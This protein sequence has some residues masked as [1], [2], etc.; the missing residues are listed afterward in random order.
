MFRAPREP[1]ALGVP[2]V[3]L[4]C[5]V[6]ASCG[7]RPGL[8]RAGAAGAGGGSIVVGT[9]G[10]AGKAAGAGGA[11]GAP[12]GAACAAA[13]ECAAPA[14]PCE[15]ATCEAGRCALAAV[16]AGTVVAIDQP[17]D[18][19]DTVCDGAGGAVKVLDLQ[20]V[21]AAGPCQINACGDDGRIVGGVAVAGAPCGGG[22]GLCDGKGL[23]V[24]CLA[25]ADCNGPLICDSSRACV[26]PSCVDGVQ[27][28]AE[29]DVDCGGGACA[30]CA[31]GQG[32]AYDADCGSGLC[33]LSDHVC[34]TPTCT[35]ERK[36][37]DETDIDCGGSCG[38]C[39]TARECRVDA[40]C[41]TKAC[42]SGLPHRCLLDHCLDGHKDF[43]ETDRDCGG[44]TCAKC[45]DFQGCKQDADCQSGHCPPARGWCLTATCFNGVH[46]GNETGVDCGGGL[47]A[48]CALGQGCGI[49]YDCASNA[50]DFVALTC[51]ADACADHRLEN[52]E[53][54]IDCG[55]QCGATCRKGQSCMVNGDC[56]PGLTCN[57]WRECQ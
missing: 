49:D 5:A 41:A 32:C 33:H 25:D 28:G 4:V 50:C 44:A 51:I 42:F 36:D 22:A 47:C 6:A 13:S 3:L 11:T 31:N 19:F 12:P 27:N 48:A 30:R 43:D 20:N 37:G 53:T 54:D 7:G 23:C 40:D 9:G 17:A 2:G 35:D 45:I 38:T 24:D 55:G 29:S 56:L 21:P 52:G 39:A 14:G 34:G 8:P 15:T 18:C 1:R 26:P 57:D 10:G 16:V 46:D